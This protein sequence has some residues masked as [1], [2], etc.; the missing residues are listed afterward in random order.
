[1]KAFIEEYLDYSKKVRNLRPNT[2]RKHVS[3]CKQWIGY[4]GEKNLRLTEV[5]PEDILSWIEYRENA[6]AKDVT[7]SGELCV[8][9]T[10]YEYLYHF[11]KMGHNPAK[12]LPELICK[13]AAETDYLSVNEC[14]R[15]LDSFDTNTPIGLRNYTIVA[16]LWCTGLR[17]N[18][19]CNLNWSDIHLTDA[20][21]LV[22]DGK[23]G[24]QRQIFLNDRLAEDFRRYKE[25]LGGEEESPVFFAF[26]T[27]AP[28]AQKHKRLSTHRVVDIIRD[29]AKAVGITKPVNPR[30]FRHTFATHMYE[31]GVPIEDLKEIMG[32]TD[33]TET[34]IYIHV[35]IGAAKRLLS[36]HIANGNR[37]PL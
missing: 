12:A 17:N 16:L 20:T 26:S 1:M 32:H 13:S 33:K 35:T 11:G 8:L 28:G 29:Q 18:E 19:L 24:A 9:R 37:R 34:T 27:N 2:L 15:L 23:G 4:I 6:G 5:S 21:L 14:F 3:T 22:R 25:K 30:T 31:A 36:E 10:L 7:I